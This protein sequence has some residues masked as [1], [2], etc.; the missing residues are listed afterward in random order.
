MG[1]QIDLPPTILS[2]FDLTFMLEDNPNRNRDEQ[3]AKYILDRHG[4]GIAYGVDPSLLKKYIA[5]SKEINPELTIE[6]KEELVGFYK[7]LRNAG[8]ESD[9]LPITARQL[10]ALVRL[11]EAYARM[12]LSDVVTKQDA[13]MAIELEMMCL[14]KVGMDDN[15]S[16]DIDKVEGRLPKTDRDK[17]SLIP[18]IIL[19]LEDE[20]EGKCPVNILYHKLNDEYNIDKKSA[21]KILNILRRDSIIFEPENGYLKL[22]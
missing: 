13:K 6:A 15:G 16:M 20:F 14:Q 17:M 1:E 5:Y 2:R 3:L 11:S 9:P 7:E 8:N 21:D 19:R 4:R 12:R 22:V 10:E 18:E